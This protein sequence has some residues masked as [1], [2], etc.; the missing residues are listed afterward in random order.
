MAKLARKSMPDREERL[1]WVYSE[2]DRLYPPTQTDQGGTK[3]SHPLGDAGKVGK[4]VGQNPTAQDSGPIQGLGQIPEDWPTL[5]SNASL[6]AELAW[7]Q[8]N[9]L[10]IVE[11][12]PSGATVVHLERAHSPAPSHAAL[13]WLETSIRSYAK[14][15]DVAARASGGGDDEGAVV[16]RERM[17]ID[18]VT[19]LIDEMREDQAGEVCQRCGRE[20]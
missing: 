16:R 4:A 9:R 7:V 13:G 5:P 19:R 8:A 15:V 11:E 6:S 1:R 18:D 2:L 12:Q 20:G 17:A 10:S 3:L 14:Y